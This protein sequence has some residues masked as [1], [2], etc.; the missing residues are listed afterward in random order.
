M[1][2]DNSLGLGLDDFKY[3]IIL[4]AI[5]VI[6]YSILSILSIWYPSEEIDL[7]Q[8]IIYFIVIFASITIIIDYYNVKR[9]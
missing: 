4:G 5:S 2:K 6:L 7:V 8:T 9:K 1:S 3:G